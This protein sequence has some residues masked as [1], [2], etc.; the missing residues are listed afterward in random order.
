MVEHDLI[1]V[2]MW[3]CHRAECWQVKMVTVVK[4]VKVGGVGIDG[5]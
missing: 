2:G 4:V 1:L 5:D 3:R